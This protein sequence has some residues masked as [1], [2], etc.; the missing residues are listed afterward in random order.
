MPFKLKETLQVDHGPLIPSSNFM[1]LQAQAPEP[2]L[3]VSAEQ[4]D[5]AAQDDGGPK[6]GL[7]PEGNKLLDDADAPPE[8]RDKTE[9]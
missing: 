6:D 2:E 4:E 7:D 5:G 1:M 3:L 8:D 9:N